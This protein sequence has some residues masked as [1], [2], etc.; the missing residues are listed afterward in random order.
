M[1][2]KKYKDNFWLL[3]TLLSVSAFLSASTPYEEVHGVESHYRANRW[4]CPH[5]STL[6][7]GDGGWCSEC[8][9]HHSSTPKEEEKEP[10]N[11]TPY[12]DEWDEWPY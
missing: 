12:R 3:I 2:S 7:G 8:G 6:N 10:E 5:C 9:R 1:K 4:V 11:P